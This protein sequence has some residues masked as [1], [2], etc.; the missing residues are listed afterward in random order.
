LLSQTQE[1]NGPPCY[2]TTDWEAARVS[3]EKL[4][5][6]NSA[7]AVCGHGIPM[8]G[9][10]LS[11]GLQKLAENFDDLAKPDYGKYVNMEG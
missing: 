5:S 4:A 8:S 6:L 3:V 1:V 9:D 10:V 11:K 7:L 2:L